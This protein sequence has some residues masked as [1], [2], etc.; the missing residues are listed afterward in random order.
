M[1]AKET[2]ISREKRR[3]I[4]NSQV[5]TGVEFE[6]ALLEAQA[7]ISFKMGM[8]EE[9]SGG[10]NSIS[11][12]EGYQEGEKAGIK[13]VVDWIGKGQTAASIYDGQISAYDTKYDN[14]F[15]IDLGDWQAQLKEWGIKED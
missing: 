11:Y 12:L 7:E 14:I 1:E 13:E 4:F 9:A 2:V 5:R 3:E 10:C 15:I 8:E 6:V